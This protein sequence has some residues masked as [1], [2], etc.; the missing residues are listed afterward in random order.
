MSNDSTLLIDR[1]LSGATTPVQSRPGSYGNE[2]V[3]RIPQSF[4][5]TGASSS[6][7]PMSYLGHWL[8]ESYSPAEM[9][10]EYSTASA[11][12]AIIASRTYS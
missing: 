11:D 10:S 2:G 4:S 3:L 5:I 12:W 9:Q 8:G 1:T 6:D 7:G